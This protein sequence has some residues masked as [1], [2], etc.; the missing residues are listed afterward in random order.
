MAHSIIGRPAPGE[1]PLAEPSLPTYPVGRPFRIQ[2]DSCSN[3]SSFFIP[4]GLSF[5]V[6]VVVRITDPENSATV[7][8]EQR[9][10][11]WVRSGEEG[12]DGERETAIFEMTPC[13]AGINVV[14]YKL[15]VSDIFGRTSINASNITR[16][17]AR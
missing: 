16:F 2:V 1:A 11:R 14:R 6:D 5:R 9:R 17:I 12:S 7:D 8:D 4:D 10:S 3:P 15:E 13:R